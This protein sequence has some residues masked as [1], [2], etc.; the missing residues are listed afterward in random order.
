MPAA[1]PRT[2]LSENFLSYLTKTVTTTGKVS[3]Q[4]PSSSSSMSPSDPKGDSLLHKNVSERLRNLPASQIIFSF[5]H[6]PSMSKKKHPR[7][8]NAVLY[9]Q[10]LLRE[11]NLNVLT[12]K[13][14]NMRGDG[15]ALLSDS[16]WGVTMCIHQLIVCT[17]QICY[18]F[19]CHLSILSQQKLKKNEMK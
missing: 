11:W 15:C 12:V 5:I 16:T 10:S 14:V 9:N 18:N 8:N 3:L 13:K 4:V 7:V 19:S 6:S 1:T 2:L 17:L